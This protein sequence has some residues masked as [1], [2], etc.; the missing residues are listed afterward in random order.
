MVT[1]GPS[2]GNKYGISD[3]RIIFSASLIYEEHQET[4]GI[5]LSRH[6]RIHHATGETDRPV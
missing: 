2:L 1:I 4:A 3:E 6:G 5:L